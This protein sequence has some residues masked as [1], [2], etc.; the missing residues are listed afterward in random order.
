MRL[1][2]HIFTMLINRMNVKKK[3]NDLPNFKVMSRLLMMKIYSLYLL[4]YQ[5]LI[6]ITCLR[7]FF[8]KHPKSF[9]KYLIL[10]TLLAQKFIAVSKE[11]KL[12]I[13][14]QNYDVSYRIL[15]YGEVYLTR[16]THLKNSNIKHNKIS[17]ILCNICNRS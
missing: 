3:I 6:N 16:Y 7:N 10:S 17:L 11:N 13:E 8:R 4:K 1:L 14:L 15:I 12:K 5:G 2:Y 9:L